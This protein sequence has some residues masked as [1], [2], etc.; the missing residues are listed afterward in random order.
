MRGSAA[1]SA[2]ASGVSTVASESAPESAASSSVSATAAESASVTTPASL[3][4]VD[5]S[6]AATRSKIAT[7]VS[8]RTQF[9]EP[10]TLSGG[11]GT[12]T[13]DGEAGNRDKLFGDEDD[14]DLDGGSGRL[15][16]CD[17][18]DGIDTATSDCENVIDVP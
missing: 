11:P 7:T 15:D 8:P 2:G 18:G 3:G 9:A 1:E 16:L 17:G 6:D 14:D 12:D 13:L 5:E 4:T 10:C